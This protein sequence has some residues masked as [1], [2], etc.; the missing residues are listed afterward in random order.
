MADTLRQ[1][2]QALEVLLQGYGPYKREQL[3]QKLLSKA[4]LLRDEV[5]RASISAEK[6][7]RLGSRA[8]PAAA[9]PEYLASE[10]ADLEEL[11]R[12]VARWPAARA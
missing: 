7:A 4:G 10:A 12:I 11:A 9:A 3:R 2:L 5:L 1:K 8:T 6:F